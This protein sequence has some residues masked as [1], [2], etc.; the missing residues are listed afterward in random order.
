MGS[1]QPSNLVLRCGHG[2]CSKQMD[3][4]DAKERDVTVHTNMTAPH[5]ALVT[6]PNLQAT[7]RARWCYKNCPAETVTATVTGVLYRTAGLA[8]FATEV[9]YHRQANV[10]IL[11]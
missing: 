5:P 10:D 3:G 6:V 1:V 11:L 7:L 9:H 4:R 8:T 2:I